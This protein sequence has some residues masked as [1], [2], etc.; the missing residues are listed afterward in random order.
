MGATGW[1]LRSMTIDLP[2]LES[3]GAFGVVP[4][5]TNAAF[6]DKDTTTASRGWTV[7]WPVTSQTVTRSLSIAGLGS[8]CGVAWNS[9]AQ[10]SRVRI[11][12][13]PFWKWNSNT[14]YLARR[15]SSNLVLDEERE[16]R[17][18]LVP[19]LMCYDSIAPQYYKI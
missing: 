1:S 5:G 12:G 17:T 11:M 14:R 19:T 16:R 10:S 13:V 3:P 9:I 4:F 15:R 8:V 6:P 18:S 2:V 7:A